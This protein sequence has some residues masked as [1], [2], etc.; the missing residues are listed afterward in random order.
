MGSIT[1]FTL[2]LYKSTYTVGNTK[3]TEIQVTRTALR[4]HRIEEIKFCM[5][6]S[7][8]AYYNS[9]TFTHFRQ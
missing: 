5:N 2:R 9:N 3:V 6:L 8:H 7:K 1:L 4:G